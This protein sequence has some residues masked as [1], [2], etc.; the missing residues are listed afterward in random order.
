M[1]RSGTSESSWLNSFFLLAAH[2]LSE[3]LNL[4]LPTLPSLQSS[5]TSSFVTG[6]GSSTNAQNSG[7]EMGPQSLWADEEEKKFYED[8]RELRGEVPAVILGVKDEPPPNT[9]EAA[10]KEEEGTAAAVGENA[11]VKLSIEREE[12]RSESLIEADGAAEIE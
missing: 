11:E 8:L 7:E 10:A 2:R 5:L 4:P 6:A 9:E 3:L 1:P 12:P